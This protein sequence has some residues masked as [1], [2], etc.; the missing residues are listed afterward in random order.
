MYWIFIAVGVLAILLLIYIFYPSIKKLWGGKRIRI[1]KEK[2]VKKDKTPEVITPPVKNED[3]EIIQN[4]GDLFKE[5]KLFDDPDTKVNYKNLDLGDFFEDDNEILNI[6]N[7][8]APRTDNLYGNK[9]DD[10]VESLFEEFRRESI[11]DRDVPSKYYSYKDELS[12]IMDSEQ[13]DKN[14][15][16]TQ[17][18]KMS[19]EMKALFISDIL[20]R[21]DD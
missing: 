15:V 21:V 14:D 2:R 11:K 8:K 16:K 17:F 9:L 18:E 20:K 7:V 4:Y 1:V 13:G 19:D 12:E 3:I 5:E 6:T 10:D